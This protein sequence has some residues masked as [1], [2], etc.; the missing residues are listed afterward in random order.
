MSTLV[1]VL[2]FIVSVLLGI[3]V[4][5]QNPKGGGLASSFGAANQIGGVR[6]TADFLE[7]ATWG[8]AIGL[9]VLCLFSTALQDQTN[10]STVNEDGIEITTPAPNE[11]QGLPSE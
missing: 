8:L 4:L 7:K 11:G 3:I 6:R 1:I 10:I 9:V 2:I 5:I